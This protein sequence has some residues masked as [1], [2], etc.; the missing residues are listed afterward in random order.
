[1]VLVPCVE[2]RRHASVEEAACP[3]CGGAL[4]APRPRPVLGGR[5]T[6][7]TIFSASLAG[8]YVAPDPQRPPPPPP[9][10]DETTHHHQP[11]P[12]PPD[13]TPPP[14][15]VTYAKPPAG[16]GGVRGRIVDANGRPARVVVHL[17]GNAMNKTTRTDPNGDYV[18]HDVPDGAYA[19]EVPRNEGNQH[20][21]HRQGPD[22]RGVKVAGQVVTA[23]LQLRPVVVPVPDNHC[24]KPY[25][26]P[27]A[28]R[29]VV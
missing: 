22:R 3:F 13:D 28:R 26:A 17:K 19:I 27:P 7:A 1:M 14:D 4:A 6:R 21:R 25:G 12:P 2:C 10:P 9:P 15:D 23:D 18:F 29:R 11:P 5:V 24:C 20:P 16:S 8:C